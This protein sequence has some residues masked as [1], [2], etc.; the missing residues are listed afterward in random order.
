MKKSLTYG[1]NDA[2]PVICACCHHHCPLRV[3]RVLR[4]H[5]AAAFASAE[6]MVHQEK[7]PAIIC[8]NLQIIQI[9]STKWIILDNEYNPPIL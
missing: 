9:I 7:P 8:D 6:V 2:R 1:P 3:R 4:A 5:A